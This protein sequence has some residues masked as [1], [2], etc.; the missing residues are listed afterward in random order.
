MS[1]D[2]YRFGRCE[3][4]VA[5]RELLVDGAVRPIERRPFD[6][7]VYLLRHRHRVISKD[8][9]L[10]AVW[11]GDCVTPGA[12]ASAMLKLRRLIE[13]KDPAAVL[14]STAHR[15]GYRFGGTVQVTTDAPE[16]PPIALAP[17]PAPTGCALAL[18]PFENQTGEPD[19]D[20]VELG[21]VTMV[22]RALAA[23][24]RLEVSAITSV[25]AALRTLPVDSTLAQRANALHRL[26]GV[27][28]VVHAAIAGG[29]G[30]YRLDVTLAGPA[31]TVSE[32][33]AGPDLLQL[34]R[35]LAARLES[36]VEP[37][38]P[39][40]FAGFD[41]GS[42]A[43]T[44]TLGR[45]MQAAA[46]N[47]WHVAL[48]LLDA[49]LQIEPDHPVA[50]LERLRSLVALDDNA[51]FDTGHALLQAARDGDNRALEAD[52]QLELAQAYLKRRLNDHARVHLDE[53]LQAAE[54]QE[55]TAWRLNL[56]LLRA[57]LALGQ[58][59]WPTAA[60]MLDRAEALCQ[61][62][63]NVFDRIRTL[64]TQ[65]I[66]EATTGDMRQAWVHAGQ[67]A[68]LYR[69]HGILVGQARAECNYANA[70]GSLGLCHLAERHGELALS[71]SRDMNVW[72]STAVSA[73]ML[74]GLYRQMRKPHHLAR[75]LRD[76]EQVHADATVMNPMYQLVGRA[77]LAI[78][79]QQYAEAADRLQ[80]AAAHARG[81]G[82]GLEHH[83]VLPLLAAAQLH[84]GQPE[85]ALAT[86]AQMRTGPHADHDPNLQ[87][88][89]LHCE[90]QV[91]LA[92]GDRH[93][94]LR[95]LREARGIAPLGWWHA[96]A[97]LDGAWL[98]AE[99]GAPAEAHALV[100]GLDAWLD[101]HPVGQALCAR[102][103]W[104]EQR[105]AEARERHERLADALG[106]AMPAFWAELGRHYLAA[107]GDLPHSSTAALPMS[108]RLPTW[109]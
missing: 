13:D 28:R 75:V 69:Q 23:D 27:Q 37:R 81:A 6:L 84:A 77:Q 68:E 108:P 17:S 31:G 39:A 7:M 34:A 25:L 88:A 10:N 19:L 5:T 52:V 60:R 8:E 40:H 104:A 62:S 103:A 97:S 76:L 71:L 14:I 107:G 54:G 79:R 55:S 44:W 30:G 64:S 29:E 4:R 26:L 66:L 99:A 96:H 86:C 91:A 1:R 105:F 82:R 35:S 12:I 47:K 109:V 94:A 58:L 53:A 56:G 106:S 65:V 67:A 33:L 41:G 48:S 15:I 74:C 80:E 95:K 45:A 24:R 57:E 21:L 46:E 83:F 90:A 38:A 51:A 87:A 3:L 50:R 2:V 70:S 11:A 89:A 59:D 72:A 43:A 36:D 22:Q 102:L 100:Q 98:A 20:W 101:E 42:S 63:G 18:L 93:A 32:Q 61:V 73:S 9:L 85:Q 49:V 16:T 92:R 78:A